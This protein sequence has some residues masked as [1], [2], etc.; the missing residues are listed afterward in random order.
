MHFIDL[1]TV[2]ETDTLPERSAPGR[3]PPYLIEKRLLPNPDSLMIGDVIL[4]SP[5]SP[6][7]NQKRIIAKQL[8]AHSQDHA[9]WTHAA[10][11]IGSGL[12]CEAVL[13][14]VREHPIHDYFQDYK[15]R[16]RRASFASEH[17]RFLVAIRAMRRLG[18][19]YSF[20]SIY[21]IATTP[22]RRFA[23]S[24]GQN[25]SQRGGMRSM[26]CSMLCF[27]SYFE[28]TNENPINDAVYL[29]TPADFSMSNK[30]NDVNV[31]LLRLPQ[32]AVV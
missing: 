7:K 2:S 20:G 14:G 23:R 6:T 26:I 29:P 12:V 21:V 18:A 13:K 5:R 30:F 22:A 4:I 31:G 1:E 24:G 10:I 15:V 8:S 28:V 17:E 19:R 32:P 16:V 27:D 9:C 25:Y 11:Y 3:L